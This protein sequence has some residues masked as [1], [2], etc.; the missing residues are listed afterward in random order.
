[1][2]LLFPKAIAMALMERWVA[3][4]MTGGASAPRLVALLHGMH[5]T[6]RSMWTFQ[7]AFQR[8]GL[9]VLNLD[10]PCMNC[11]LEESADRLAA[12]LAALNGLEFDL[13][14]HSMGGLVARTL[15]SRHPDLRVRR[16][17]LIG[18]PNHGSELAA[19]FRS[20]RL[21]HRLYGKAAA[22]LPTENAFLKSLPP[23]RCEFGII[24][25]G[26]GTKRFGIAP[27]IRG[28]NDGLVS[29]A[30]AQLE[31]ARD[32]IVLKVDHRRQLRSRKVI[33]QTLHFLNHGRF[34]R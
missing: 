32:F 16:A 15:L 12:Q 3:P 14:A 34:Q 18:T 2:L 17:V 23:P 19:K 27:W 10:Y 28:D 22:A 31:G 5:R 25:G 20:L 8:H 24:A 33:N 6:A 9:L 30:S 13:V 21:F 29:V 1:M 4:Q 26:L 11:T 7:R